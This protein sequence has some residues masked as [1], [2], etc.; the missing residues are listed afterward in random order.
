MKESLTK[1]NYQYLKY[2]GDKLHLLLDVDTGREEIF[3][4]NKN[5]SSW[6]LIYKNTHLE[7]ASSHVASRKNNS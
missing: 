3:L 4:S 7:F 2:L 5:H 6:G 1:A